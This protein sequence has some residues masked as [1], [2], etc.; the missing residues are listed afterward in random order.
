MRGPTQCRGAVTGAAIAAL[1]VVGLAY[2]AAGADEPVIQARQLIALP[3]DS[4]LAI[5]PRDDSDENLRLRD[6]MVAR[7]HERHGRVADDAPLLLRFTTASVSARDAKA[8]AGR[9]GGRGGR[10]VGAALI[11]G[12]HNADASK[13]AAAPDNRVRY[14][15][16]ATIERRDGG[17]VLWQSEITAIP[18]GDN[19]RRLPAELAALLVDNI[20]RTVDTRPP[21]PP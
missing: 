6:L 18:D 13:P 3:P 20:G 9:G 1:L 5:E 7:L 12:A 15:V 17:E 14:R 11:T 8:S 4:A 21:P 2:P 19:A 16:T 10:N